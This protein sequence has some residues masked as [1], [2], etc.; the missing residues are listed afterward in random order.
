MNGLFRKT[1]LAL[2]AA[3]CFGTGAAN[4]AEVDTKG[5][6]KVKSDDGQF[7]GEFNGRMHYDIYGFSNDGNIRNDNGDDFRRLRLSGKGT[8]YGVYEGK[9][10]IDFRTNRANGESSNVVMR[11]VWL[12]Y[13][14]FEL[15]K[16][17]AGHQK[18]PMGLD[19]L[20]SSN[21]IWFIERAAPVSLITDGA[22]R[23]GLQF[24]G[25]RGNWTY[26]VMGYDSNNRN[27]AD[28]DSGATERNGSAGFGYGGRL[29]WTPLKDKAQVL[30]LGLS[31]A[32]EEAENLSDRT[33][34]YEANLADSVLVADFLAAPDDGD[35]LTK[36]GIEAAYVS[37]PFS[38][39]AEYLNAKVSSDAA[40]DPEFG[41]YYV[42][43]SYF[44]TGE[45][46]PYRAS[47]G[48]FDRIKPNGKNGAW[49]VLARYS[50]VDGEVDT[51]DDN[52]ISNI[53]LGL[54]YYINPQI[55]LMA[56]IMQADVDANGAGAAAA[57]RE[58]EPRT[59]AF[60]A[61]FD[62]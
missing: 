18:V 15:G 60:R 42:A 34:R 12:S 13:S 44:L 23:R 20:T 1:A 55:R 38:M 59:L 2:A 57:R 26:A 52:E 4:A 40:G 58:G 14:G 27:A 10:E 32:K 51:R 62:F 45:S 6:I 49:E 36:Y 35:D 16:L 50:T 61:Q 33:T 54:N 22:H 37:G 21:Y 11:D 17:T 19:E 56:N 29:T 43:A 8:M 30:H 53:T 47:N 25:Q 39:Q 46:R 5:G 9:I 7:V 41:G 48:T 28:T 31:A 3:G 24:S